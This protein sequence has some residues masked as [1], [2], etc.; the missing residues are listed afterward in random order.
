VSQHYG[1]GSTQGRR[2][3]NEDMGGHSMRSTLRRVAVHLWT[4][5][6]AAIVAPVALALVLAVVPVRP[7][8]QAAAQMTAV[9]TVVLFAFF[10]VLRRGR[11]KSIQSR[12]EHP[13]V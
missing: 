8:M 10:T 11:S 13:R 9:I 1:V 5:L 12:P 4:A 2:G 3:Y 7:G 6:W